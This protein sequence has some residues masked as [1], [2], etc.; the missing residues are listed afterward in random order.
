MTS[1][2][3]VTLGIPGNGDPSA[4]GPH[5]RRLGYGVD[6]VVRALGVDVWADPSTSASAVSSSNTTT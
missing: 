2:V 1:R 6:G 4:R 5:G 3:G